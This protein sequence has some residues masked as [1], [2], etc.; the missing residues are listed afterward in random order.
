MSLREGRREGGKE[1]RRKGRE[2]GREV[3]VVCN[4]CVMIMA[5]RI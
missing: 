4:A 3:C 2:K 1:G 5:G